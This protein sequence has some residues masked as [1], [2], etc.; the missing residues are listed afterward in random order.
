MNA[1]LYGTSNAICYPWHAHGRRYSFLI[2]PHD[3]QADN[4]GIA[5]LR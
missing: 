1:T 2:T 3:N 4:G 5:L